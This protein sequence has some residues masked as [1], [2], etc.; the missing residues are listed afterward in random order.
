MYCM[1][2]MSLYALVCIVC[3]CMYW[4]FLVSTHRH[5]HTL[6]AHTDICILGHTYALHVC[7]YIYPP[8]TCNITCYFQYIHICTGRFT[9]KNVGLFG[10]IWCRRAGWCP[11]RRWNWG[12][13]PWHWGWGLLR[14]NAQVPSFCYQSLLQTLPKIGCPH[15]R[16]TEEI[17]LRDIPGSDL[18]A[19]LDSDWNC[20]MVSLWIDHVGCVLAHGRQIPEN[21]VNKQHALSPKTEQVA[22]QLGKSRVG[23]LHL[24]ISKMA[25]ILNLRSCFVMTQ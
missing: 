18:W 9:D 20:N 24:S 22:S 3:I 12:C 8:N 1:Y 17:L 21:L 10:L 6:H 7:V 4:H 2:C 23:P 15:H 25:W 5:I 16:I 19:T 13:F 11:S 14:C